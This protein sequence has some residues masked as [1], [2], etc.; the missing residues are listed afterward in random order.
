MEAAGADRDAGPIS[1][2]ASGTVW[3]LQAGRGLAALA[4]LFFH[5]THAATTFSGEGQ[6][7]TYGARGVEFFFVLSGFII[8]RV[9]R[10]RDGNWLGSFAYRRFARVFLPYLPVG[11]ALGVIYTALP[12]LSAD[13]RD[14]S[15]LPTLTLLPF[16]TPA[17]NPAWTLQHE[18]LFYGLMAGFLWL[19]HL[20][21]GLVIWSVLIALYWLSG[22]DQTNV[23]LS[24]INLCFGLGVAAAALVERRWVR[25]WPAA[26]A[27]SVFVVSG[28]YLAFALAV[29]LTLPVLVKLEQAGRYRVPAWLGYLGTISYS[30]Y[31]VH[32]PLVSVAARL[33]PGWWETVLL[34]CCLSLV[35]A[36]AYHHSVELP[37]MRLARRGV[38][39]RP[40][41]RWPARS[42][43]RGPA[44]WFRLGW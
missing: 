6:V 2:K 26:L 5:A 33:A 3:S 18:V 9:S 12:G 17:L 42:P 10:R 35:G 41:L 27:W 36:V 34:G 38:V 22:G 40:Y 16:G 14:W 24:P 11:I 4:V 39:A 19:R 44:G 1:N 13:D 23:F 32:L 29:A 25:I 31:L 28:H 30:L 20:A 43:S 21:A 15:W 8:Y 7:F 37:L